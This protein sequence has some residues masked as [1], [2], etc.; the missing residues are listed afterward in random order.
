MALSEGDYNEQSRKVQP[1]FRTKVKAPI[2]ARQISYFEGC[3]KE[4]FNLG[5]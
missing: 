5:D 2:S 3:G 1:Q 4:W